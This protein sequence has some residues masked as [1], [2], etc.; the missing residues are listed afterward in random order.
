MIMN[1]LMA[2]LLV[3]KHQSAET[4]Y[5]DITGCILCFSSCRQITSQEKTDSRKG[6][7]WLSN[8]DT[9]PHIPAGMVGGACHG[10]AGRRAG[11]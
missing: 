1:S 3:P 10:A 11:T 7:S 9:G 4:E 2:Q 6:L 5:R 8:K